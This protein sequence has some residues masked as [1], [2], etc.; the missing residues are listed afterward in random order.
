[1]N[2]QEQLNLLSE[3]EPSSD[4]QKA[5]ENVTQLDESDNEQVSIT[6]QDL[7]GFKKPLFS[8]KELITFAI[9]SSSCQKMSKIDIYNWIINS[10]P[11]Y[12]Y[13]PASFKVS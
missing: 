8:Y 1:M 13:K 12:N 7:C 3:A 2:D 11:Y 10:F 9:N 6:T 5:S 4:N